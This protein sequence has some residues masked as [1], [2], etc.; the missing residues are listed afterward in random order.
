MTLVLIFLVIFSVLFT[1]V[2]YG[3]MVDTYDFFRAELFNL[4]EPNLKLKFIYTIAGFLF[5]S[6]LCI[7]IAACIS[8]YSSVGLTMVLGFAYSIGSTLLNI[9]GLEYLTPAG[10]GDHVM[11]DMSLLEAVGNSGLVT[12]VY[13]VILVFFTLKYFRKLE[14]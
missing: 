10:M 11:K 6:V 2:Y 1:A 9:F 3:R 4:Q 14:F 5:D 8:L 13:A 7:L 12:A